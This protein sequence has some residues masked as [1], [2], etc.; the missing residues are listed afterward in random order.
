MEK[1]LPNAGWTYIDYSE[2]FHSHMSAPTQMSCRSRPLV[3]FA[4]TTVKVY[5]NCPPNSPYMA[6]AIIKTVCLSA[7]DSSNLIQPANS[8]MDK[9]SGALRLCLR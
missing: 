8:I 2:S 1:P 5:Q 7:V 4:S 6:S 3:K 9:I